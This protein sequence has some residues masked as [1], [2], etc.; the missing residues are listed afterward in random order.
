[1]DRIRRLTERPHDRQHTETGAT[2]PSTDT[3]HLHTIE[4]G[5]T[6]SRPVTHQPPCALTNVALVLV[7]R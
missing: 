2:L 4:Y 5:Q 6:R 1:M 7:R 3:H